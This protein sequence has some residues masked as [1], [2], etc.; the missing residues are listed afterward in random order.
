MLRGRPEWSPI[1]FMAVLFPF[2]RILIKMRRP[3]SHTCARIWPVA[4]PAPRPTPGRSHGRIRTPPPAST[5]QTWVWPG[6]KNS[7][8]LVLEW[9]EH[10]QTVVHRQLHPLDLQIISWHVPL[11]HHVFFFLGT[12]IMYSTTTTTSDACMMSSLQGWVKW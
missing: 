5:P 2:Q 8:R 6:C 9:C 11:P 3:W 10:Q 1:T 12:H 4:K 7:I